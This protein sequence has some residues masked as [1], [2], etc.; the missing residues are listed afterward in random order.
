MDGLITKA[1]LFWKHLKKKEQSEYQITR[2]VLLRVLGFVYFFAFLS[3]ALQIAPLVGQDGLLPAHDF[4]DSYGNYYGN[5]AFLRLPTVFWLNHSD[6][7]LIFMSWLGAL[8]SLAVML[9][10]ANS[11][12]MF[13]LWIFYMSFVNIGQV[14]Y[15]YGWEIQ[16]LETGFL[17][18]FLC[19]LL[20]LRPFPKSSP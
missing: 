13:F 2:F 14:F 7:F 20:D 1:G 19:P 6:G 11:I 9:G 15:N 17:A 3:L 12:I 10:S 8:L 5:G 16:L 4:L 18:I